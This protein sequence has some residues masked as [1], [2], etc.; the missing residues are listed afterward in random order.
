MY[1]LKNLNCWTLLCAVLIFSFAISSC[2]SDD[3]DENNCEANF[4]SQTV[5]G[6]FMGS[7]FTVVEGTTEE[8]FADATKFRITLYGET[9][10]G[11]ACDN[12]NFDKPPFSIIFSVPM[13]TGTYELGLSSY[14]LTFNDASVVNEVNAVVSVCG[15]IEITAVTN[16]TVTG[17]IDATGDT[18]NVLNGNFTAVRCL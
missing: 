2:G 10:T 1:K 5:T 14:S 3:S 16:D 7:T 9:V 8:D 17:K 6:E 4:L 15:A 11:D 12:F 13:V 18:D